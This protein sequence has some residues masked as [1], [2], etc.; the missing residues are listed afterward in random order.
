[1]WNARSGNKTRKNI[2]WIK[3]ILGEQRIGGRP[4]IS[5]GLTIILP[6]CKSIVHEFRRKKFNSS[7]M[8]LYP[9]SCVCAYVRR[10]HTFMGKS[11]RSMVTV[12]SWFNVYLR[13]SSMHALIYWLCPGS[14]IAETSERQRRLS[15][16][17][18]GR[19]DAGPDFDGGVDSIS[20]CFSQYVW[21]NK[22]QAFS[23]PCIEKKE[24]I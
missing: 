14:W 4:S 7:P 9:T 16:R 20:K 13:K 1:M 24:T 21:T 15:G 3:D 22:K 5:H 10:R 8:L 23:R 12:M 17:P 2:F 11:Y 19:F 6:S 18:T